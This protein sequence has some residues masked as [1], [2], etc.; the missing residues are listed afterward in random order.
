MTIAVYAK[1]IEPGMTKGGYTVKDS[2]P[3][4]GETRIVFS[5]PENGIEIEYS[6]VMPDYSVLEMD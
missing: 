4:H 2:Y 3:Y 6:C 1:D 5:Y